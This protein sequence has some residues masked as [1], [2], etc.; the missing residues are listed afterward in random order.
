MVV[1]LHQNEWAM[2]ERN[3]ELSYGQGKLCFFPLSSVLA[4]RLRTLVVDL[5]VFPLLNHIKVVEGV[6][7]SPS[8]LSG[9]FAS[10][11]EWAPE[12]LRKTPAL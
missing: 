6:R 5:A 9:A 4:T 1:A 2:N 11:A 7:D 10:A 8:C 12:A 3:V